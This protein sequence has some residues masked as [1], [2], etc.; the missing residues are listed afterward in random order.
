MKLRE[1]VVI[2]EVEQGTILLDTRRG[3]Y[4]HLNDL[5][6]EVLRSIVAGDSLDSVVDRLATTHETDRRTVAD[7]CRSLI[8]ELRA[9]RLVSG[10][11]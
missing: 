3:R 1:G 7:D 6:I 4:W 2:T 10:S 8:R 11:A 5:G 9:V